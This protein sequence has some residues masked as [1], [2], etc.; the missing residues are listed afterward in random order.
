MEYADGGDLY[1]AITHRAKEK[2][3]FDED[4]VL[5]WCG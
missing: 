3:L 2:K 1:D 5:N 4:T